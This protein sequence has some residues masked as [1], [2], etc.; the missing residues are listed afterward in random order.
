MVEIFVQPLVG[1]CA[2][3]QLLSCRRLHWSLCLA[4]RLCPV[5]NSSQQATSEENQHR[6]YFPTP[7]HS[8]RLIRPCFISQ[9]AG[10]TQPPCFISKWAG[11]AQLMF[12]FGWD[13]S[14][15]HS[16]CLW[17]RSWDTSWF[18][19]STQLGH[20][21]MSFFMFVNTLLGYQPVWSFNSVGTPAD[22]IHYVC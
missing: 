6:H 10:I 22:V 18:N 7:G 19:L 15:C 20:Q 3:A 1:T 11:I 14:Q 12:H 17:I 2:R 4:C 16:L 21:P 5:K 13:T 9:W 8:I